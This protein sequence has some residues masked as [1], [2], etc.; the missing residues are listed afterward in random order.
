[1]RGTYISPQ[2]LSLGKPL[3]LPPLPHFSLRHLHTVFSFC[4][5]LDHLLLP[6][7]R[8]SLLPIYF[9]TCLENLNL[10]S[11]F[12]VAGMEDGVYM[13]A[14]GAQ[15]LDVLV[16]GCYSP[17]SFTK[18]SMGTGDPRTAVLWA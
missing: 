17:W 6:P 1:M 12:L 5:I 13:A 15:G 4:N 18:S 11:E 2:P 3:L 16:S 14:G 8:L 7:Q 10:I 9:G